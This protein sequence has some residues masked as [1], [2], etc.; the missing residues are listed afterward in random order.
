LAN[1]VQAAAWK[2]PGALKA[3]FGSA[4]FVRDLTVFHVGGNKYRSIAFVH[5]FRQIVFVKQ[6]LTHEEYDQWDWKS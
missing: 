2:N 3:E 4:D 6:I 1:A 5:Y